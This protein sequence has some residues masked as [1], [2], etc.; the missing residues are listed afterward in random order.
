MRTLRVLVALL[1]VVIVAF[2]LVPTSPS[3]AQ[4]PA[5]DLTLIAQTAITTRDEPEVTI[6]FRAENLGDEPYE[7]LSVG[8]PNCESKHPDQVLHRASDATFIEHGEQNFGIRT[9]PK[10]GACVFEGR[11]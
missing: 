10:M 1:S 2:P 5:I 4:E 6:T 8:V 7:D 11:P 9:A 3:D